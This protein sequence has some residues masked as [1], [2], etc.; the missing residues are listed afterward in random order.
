VVSSRQMPGSLSSEEI[1]RTD[2]SDFWMWLQPA[3]YFNRFTKLF[4]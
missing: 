2:Q 4:R 3:Q 1:A